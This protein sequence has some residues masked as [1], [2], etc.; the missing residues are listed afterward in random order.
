MRRWAASLVLALLVTVAGPVTQS[1]ADVT[2]NGEAWGGYADLAGVNGGYA[3]LIA[4]WSGTAVPVACIERHGL[5]SSD[6][7]DIVN[8]D[9]T[10]VGPASSEFCHANYEGSLTF[11]MCR[12][13]AYWFDPCTAWIP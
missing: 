10:K 8:G 6:S 5:S 3:R 4:S 7:F 1:A 2:P 12:V 11:K 9:G 13:V